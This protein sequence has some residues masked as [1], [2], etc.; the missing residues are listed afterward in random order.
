MIEIE[1]RSIRS[2]ESPSLVFH[3]LAS[4]FGHR[5]IVS[6]GDLNELAGVSQWKPGVD[7]QQQ[8]IMLATEP[9]VPRN[10]RDKLRARARRNEI[11]Q[12]SHQFDCMTQGILREPSRSL[13]L[14]ASRISKANGEPRY[15]PKKTS[16]GVAPVH[17]RKCATA[18]SRSL[19]V[20][21]S[22]RIATT[23]KGARGAAN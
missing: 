5:Q 18:R 21:S 14:F 16:G 17:L 1:V 11:S 2:E 6:T 4:R 3:P 7:A 12:R 20:G 13:R 15:D 8:L 10:P 9:G 19:E 23:G 22:A